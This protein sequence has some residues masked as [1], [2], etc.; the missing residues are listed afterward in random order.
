M[1]PASV[2]WIEDRTQSMTATSS[3][4]TEGGNITLMNLTTSSQT[5]R[6]AGYMGNLTG[7]LVLADDAG[8]NFFRWNWYL[9]EEAIICAG[10]FT[11]YNWSALYEG[12]VWSVDVAWGFSG[13][14]DL[15]I[16]TFNA[17]QG[18]LSL[19]I[20]TNELTNMNSSDTGGPDP[21]D[22]DDFLTSVVNDQAV[23]NTDK[24]NILFCTQTNSTGT[25][26]AYDGT[27]ADYELIV[28]VGDSSPSD[29]E[30]YYFF[31]ELK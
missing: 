11:R 2:S 18:Q 26:N 15:A 16:Y 20:S 3:D 10:T 9:T 31:V 28:P 1:T 27:T 24:R 4:T 19:N 25:N 17:T 23:D 29:R 7:N 22:D 8:N 14:S 13:G 21:A 6:W 30:T 12:I 5:G